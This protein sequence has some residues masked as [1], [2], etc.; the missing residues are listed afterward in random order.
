[1]ACLLLLPVSD[2][3][4]DP[5]RASRTVPVSTTQKAAH[6]STPAAPIATT[7]SNATSTQSSPTPTPNQGGAPDQ[8]RP[9]ANEQPALGAPLVLP[10]NQQPSRSTT[11]TLS[12]NREIFGFATS[13]SLADPTFGYP[14]WNFDL[15][16]TVAFFA[17]HVQYDGVL[18]ADSNWTVWSSS[19]L[20]GLVNTA[21]AHGAKVV[22]TLVGPGNPVDQCD[23]LYN[24]QTTVLQIVNQV[25][26]KGIDG[27]N[28]D[29][30]GQLQMCQNNNP[31]LNELNQTLLTNFAKDMRAALDAVRPGY[32]LSI[33]TYSG[34]AAGTDG[35][36]N[37]PN[38]NQY[39]DSFF[40]MAYDMDYANQDFPPL[41][42]SG[43]LG[44]RC[45]NPISPL[46]NY[47]Y[48]DTISMG[49]YSSVVGAGKV[50]LGQPYYGRVAC[51]A[52]PVEHA[53]PISSLTAVTYVGAAAVAQSVDVQPGTFTFHRDANDPTGWDRWDSWYDLSYGCW[54]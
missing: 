13:G 30:E 20:T 23:S 11:R 37:I 44:V 5:G 8:S 45:L 35:F 28:I 22:V 34:S 14:S 24:D 50:I 27:V 16:S 9:L 48:N 4:V 42:C 18:I 21:H 38:L 19:D 32:Y 53:T 6:V 39:V 41:S 2:L 17:I 15:L 51:V 25:K 1:M 31:A 43:P 29:Y 47:N 52:S 40:V 36:F 10:P 7:L 49:Q 3:S 12:P 33:D 54:R 26:L 46:T